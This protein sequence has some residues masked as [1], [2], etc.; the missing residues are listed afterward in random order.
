MSVK[1]TLTDGQAA[2]LFEVLAYL[3]DE[4]PPGEGWQSPELEKLIAL[5]RDARRFSVK[6]K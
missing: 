3:N 4:G 2:K 6:K 1:L 5:V